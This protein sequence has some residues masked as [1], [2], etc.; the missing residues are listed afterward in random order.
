MSATLLFLVSPGILN[1][2]RMDKHTI[3]PITY[4]KSVPILRMVSD[5]IGTPSSR[6]LSNICVSFG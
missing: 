4:F 2:I 3:D 5:S 1:E 6:L